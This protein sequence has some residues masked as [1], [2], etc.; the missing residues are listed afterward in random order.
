MVPSRWH[1]EYLGSEMNIGTRYSVIRNESPKGY[2]MNLPGL[3]DSPVQLD[4]SA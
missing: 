2:V 1:P 3:H 4:T